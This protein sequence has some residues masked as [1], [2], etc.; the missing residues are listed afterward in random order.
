MIFGQERKRDSAL[1]AR[2]PTMIPY[3][4]LAHPWLIVTLVTYFAKVPVATALP[5]GW[6]IVTLVTRFA[7]VP[8]IAALP[9]L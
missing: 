3:S 6:S 1:L 9:H 5:Q 8:V 7:K 4:W 2:F